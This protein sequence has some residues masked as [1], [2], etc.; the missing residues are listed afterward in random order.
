MNYSSVARVTTEKFGGPKKQSIQNNKNLKRYIDARVSEYT[1]D[2]KYLEL[3]EKNKNNLKTK[4]YP[5]EN[6][7]L[8]T[9]TYIDQLESR[10]K[11]AET[12]YS[13]LRKW[14]ENF[15]RVNPVKYAEVIS[16]GP[17][18]TGTMQ[19]EYKPE[20]NEQL[21]DIRQGLRE[22]LNLKDFIGSL[23]EETKGEKKR[24]TL[25]RPAGDHVVLTPQQLTA[26]HY[27]LEE[28]NEQ[29]K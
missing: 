10:L 18:D 16:K 14:Q 5:V 20:N 26:I 23:E 22:L 12:R 7:D 6:L 19:L 11:L 15:T 24:L 9:Q 28:T 29:Q 17:S 21:D 8:R 4:K 27:F 3:P 25:K 13:E 1:Q 2:R